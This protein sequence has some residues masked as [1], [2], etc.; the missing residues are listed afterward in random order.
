M[1]LIIYSADSGAQVKSLGRTSPLRDIHIAEVETLI[2]DNEGKHEG[3]FD[4]P[5]L[6]S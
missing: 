5:S 6:L 3:D 4:E 2:K 1:F